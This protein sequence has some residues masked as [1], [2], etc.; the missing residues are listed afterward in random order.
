MNT[1][2][3]ESFVG[4]R[5]E[6]SASV[7]YSQ[8]K[9]F[10]EFVLGNLEGEDKTKMQMHFN[11]EQLLT[12]EEFAQLSEKAHLSIS[13]KMA[14]A[15]EEDQANLNADVDIEELRA[16]FRHSG[17][18]GGLN[19]TAGMI[20]LNPNVTEEERTFLLYDFAEN[21]SDDYERVLEIMNKGLGE[22]AGGNLKVR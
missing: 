5:E 20:I 1:Y 4:A 18:S 16:L 6:L 8:S 9:E 19:E 3:V 11:N 15:Q 10:Q 13:E 7:Q 2:A 21:K 22:G 12:P 14:Q 17:D